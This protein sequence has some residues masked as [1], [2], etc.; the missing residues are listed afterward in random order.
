MKQTE[1]RLKLK[2]LSEWVVYVKVLVLCEAEK[3]FQFPHDEIILQIQEELHSQN[4]C[5]FVTQT[6][7]YFLIYSENDL[8][9]MLHCLLCT[10]SKF[11]GL[12]LSVYDLKI[13]C[14]TH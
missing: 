13:T 1:F 9:S 6:Y 11:Y 3:V 5:V 7:K 8:S 14:L 10:Y 12:S 2:Y 4:V